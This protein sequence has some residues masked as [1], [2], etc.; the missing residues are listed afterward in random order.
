MVFI[1]VPTIRSKFFSPSFFEN[2]Q[3][4]MYRLEKFEKQQDSPLPVL[5]AF[6]KENFYFLLICFFLKFKKKTI[7]LFFFIFFNSNVQE[8][9]YGSSI[10]SGD[11]HS[12][13]RAIKIAGDTNIKNLRVHT[14]SPY[15]RKKTME[16]KMPEWKKNDWKDARGKSITNCQAY[17]GLDDA[18]RAYPQMNVKFIN[19]KDEELE[20]RRTLKSSRKTI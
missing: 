20:S 8:S 9:A 15:L 1:G 12:A 3:K 19:A 13:A 4:I 18:I 11:I 2:W 14:S 10:K 16:E 5:P 6:S 17:R 7:F